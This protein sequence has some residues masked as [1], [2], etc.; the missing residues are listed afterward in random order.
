MLM[1]PYHFIFYFKSEPQM[2]SL[3]YDV[4]ALQYTLSLTPNPWMQVTETK[5]SLI[6]KKDI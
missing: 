3:F 2:C 1:S 4:I 5:T 6:K